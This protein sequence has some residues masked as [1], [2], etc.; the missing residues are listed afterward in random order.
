MQAQAEVE[1]EERRPKRT[2]E[3][4]EVTL[5]LKPRE[6]VR[7]SGMQT[8]RLNLTLA[9]LRSK[10]RRDTLWNSFFTWWYIYPWWGSRQAERPG[11]SRDGTSRSPSSGQTTCVRDTEESKNPEQVG[12]CLNLA[13]RRGLQR[14]REMQ[15]RLRVWGAHSFK[16]FSVPSPGRMDG[17]QVP[18]ALPMSEGWMR[19]RTLGFSFYKHREEN[20]IRPSYINSYCNRQIT[21]EF[22]TKRRDSG[23]NVHCCSEQKLNSKQ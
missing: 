21:Q 4:P 10:G 16:G 17:L 20:E 1:R 19:K 9:A 12:R 7:L 13:A 2:P 8:P 15:I 11:K 23:I 14:G 3:L 6:Q 22:K 5:S 18:G